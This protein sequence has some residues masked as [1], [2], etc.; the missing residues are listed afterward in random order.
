MARVRRGAAMSA[1]L[2]A[3]MATAA[4]AV[5]APRAPA[6][7]DVPVTVP[8][9]IVPF[10]NSIVT[11]SLLSFI[12]KLRQ[13]AQ[14]TGPTSSWSQQR[15][16]NPISRDS[17]T[18]LC[19]APRD[20]HCR[21]AP[22]A[23]GPAGRDARREVPG[24]DARYRCVRVAAPRRVRVRVGSRARAAYDAVRRVRDASHPHAAALRRC[25]V[26]RLRRRAA[27][28]Q[29]GHRGRA[30]SVRRPTHPANA[31]KTAPEASR[32]TAQT[33]AQRRATRLCA[34]WT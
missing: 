5:A 7:P 1:V 3:A 33:R 30:R 22:P 16:T 19:N 11:L 31:P 23:Q 13:R 4:A 8:C 17:A 15:G 24:Q 14:P 27:P 21:A 12:K 28:E 25:A 2:A 10:F 32:C 34:A 26:R 20:G 6:R 18:R 29:G 9:T